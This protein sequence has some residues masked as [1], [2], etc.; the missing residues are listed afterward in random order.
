ME[1]PEVLNIFAETAFQGRREWTLK[2]LIL[3]RGVFGAQKATWKLSQCLQPL[4]E[5]R[6][7]I[8]LRLCG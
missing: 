1:R 7:H 3:P 4:G 6:Q 5:V 2:N 8:D